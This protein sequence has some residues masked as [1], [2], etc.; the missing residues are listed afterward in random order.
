MYVCVNDLLT[1]LLQQYKSSLS[2]N[3]F[4]VTKWKLTS[5]PN[6]TLS[7]QYI[8]FQTTVFKILESSYLNVWFE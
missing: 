5:F 4:Q 2:E 3:L 1:N 6:Y 8:C 7:E